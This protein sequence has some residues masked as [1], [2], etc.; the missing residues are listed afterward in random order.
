MQDVDL[1]A[2][3]L[4]IKAPW[5]VD[6]VDLKTDKNRIDI[7]LTHPAK[8]IWNCPEC[9][10]TGYCYDHTEERVWRHLDTCQFKTFIHAQIPRVNCP[11]HGVRQVHVPWAE[12]GSRF[13]LLMERL[14]IHVLQQ[15]STVE[16]A[17]RLVDISW[18]Q[19]WGVM[20]RAVQRGLRRKKE[21]LVRYIGI[22]EKAFRKGHKHMTVV[23]DLYRGTVEYVS[24][25]RRT[26]S[27]E[28]YYQQLTDR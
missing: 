18:D 3:I 22:D 17:R 13:T 1:Y 12:K 6:T 16:G 20:K 8:T 25:E 28:E 10:E 15:C 19:A 24:D 11:N 5:K 23:C 9:S 4:G 26:S 7:Y 2:Q 21:R 14:I 27:L